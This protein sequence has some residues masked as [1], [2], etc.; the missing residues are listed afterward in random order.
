MIVF[1]NLFIIPVPHLPSI[2][3][4]FSCRAAAFLWSSRSSLTAC[5]RCLATAGVACRWCI[6]VFVIQF[7][8]S[9]SEGEMQYPLWLVISEIRNSRKSG[10]EASRLFLAQRPPGRSS[11]ISWPCRSSLPLVQCQARSLP[12]GMCAFY[13]Y[14]R[15]LCN[16]G[17]YSKVYAQRGV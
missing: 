2:P 3:E 15:F 17:L 10:S 5:H 7:W 6:S 16:R 9:K 14:H 1:L 12:S 13:S 4:A 11:A 8:L